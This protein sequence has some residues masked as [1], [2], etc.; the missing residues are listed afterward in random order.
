M[1]L[2]SRYGDPIRNLTDRPQPS[3]AQLLIR[4]MVLVLEWM[5][6]LMLDPSSGG[7]RR[8]RWIWGSVSRRGAPALQWSLIGTRHVEIITIVTP[9]GV[10][11]VRVT[12][13]A[14]LVAKVA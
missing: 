6:P 5:L 1:H 2:L 7:C 9:V 8:S 3:G 14:A 12:F 4:T 10:R 11:G 13:D